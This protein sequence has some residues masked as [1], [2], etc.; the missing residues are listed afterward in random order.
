MRLIAQGGHG[1][2]EARHRNVE[3]QTDAVDRLG[4]LQRRIAEADAQAAQAVDLGEGAGDDDV[5]VLAGEGEARFPV[6]FGDEFRI[7]LVDDQQ[8]IGRQ[9]L[10]KAADFLGGVVAAGRVRRAGD[11]DDAGPVIDLGQDGLWGQPEVGLRRQLD[12][13]LVGQRADAIGEEAVFAADDVVAGRQIGLVQQ[14]ED[15]VRAVAEDQP[16]RLQ[17]VMLR[18]R[19]AQLRRPAV[20]IHVDMVHRGRIGLARLL[21]GA[22]GVLVGRQLH[23]LGHALDARLAADIGGDVEDAGLGIRTFDLGGV[24]HGRFQNRGAAPMTPERPPGADA[25]RPSSACT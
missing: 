7:G 25:S 22:E 2:L 12:R 10:V 8:H 9:G 17:P 1:G 5:V 13:G 23:R 3:R 18:H 11:I 6:G 21:A 24:G 15:L 20:G 4:H 16:L 14:G 19:L